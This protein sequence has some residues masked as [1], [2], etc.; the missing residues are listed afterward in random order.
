MRTQTVHYG[1]RTRASL[2]NAPSQPSRAVEDFYDYIFDKLEEPRIIKMSVNDL[3]NKYPLT[4]SDIDKLLE[5][6][7][8]HIRYEG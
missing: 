7:K 8:S 6:T 3:I 5:I 1:L 2:P 4:Q